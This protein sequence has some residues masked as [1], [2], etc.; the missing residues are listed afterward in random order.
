MEC[1]P[2]QIVYSPYVCVCVCVCEIR[3]HHAPS[4]GNCRSPAAMD[5]V[6]MI[7]NKLLLSR[8]QTLFLINNGATLAP[9]AVKLPHHNFPAY[10]ALYMLISLGLVHEYEEQSENNLAQNAADRA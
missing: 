5:T 4:W 8:Q 1:L 10:S 6:F 3:F 7:K 9:C 2:K